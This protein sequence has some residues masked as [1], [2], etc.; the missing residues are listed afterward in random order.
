MTLTLTRHTGTETLDLVSRLKLLY[1]NA[2][3]EP[4]YEM[5][6]EDI[7]QFEIRITKHAGLEGFVLVAGE[8]DGRLVGLSYGFTFPLGRWW[9]GVNTDPPPAEVAS[10]PLFAVIE[11]GV[12]TD[13]RG[14]GVSR[15]LVDALLSD[16]PEAFASP[17]FPP[18]CSGSCDVSTL[19]V[20]EGRHHTD[21]PTLAR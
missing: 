20:E 12:H 5:S 10:G 16:R 6:G 17:H 11:L 14:C 2:Y 4:P 7:E 13:F 1:A 18:R 21:V 3:S 9:T 15:Q 8:I 19:G